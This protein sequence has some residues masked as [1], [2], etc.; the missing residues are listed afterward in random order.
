MS[1]ER[2]TKPIEYYKDANG[3]HPLFDLEV[4]G[5]SSFAKTLLDDTS[6]SEIRETISAQQTLPI[7]T[8]LMYDG[9]GIADVSTRTEDIGDREGDTISLPGWKVCNGNGGT[10]NLLNKFI[11]SEA[12]SGNTGGSDDA[13]VVSHSHS[14]SIGGSGTLYTNYT[15]PNLNHRHY[16]GERVQTNDSLGKYWT[17]YGQTSSGSGYNYT[18]GK[19]SSKHNSYQGYTSYHDH[20]MSHRHSI[21]SHGHSL[22][23]NTTGV[24]GTGKNMPAYYSLIFIKKVS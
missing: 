22:T 6:A 7:G 13:V 4:Y 16:N 20:S 8:I 17:V 12:S 1:L 15:D 18:A 24:D 3:T 11:R 10:P 9:T 14:G 5:V 19:S 21:N 23:I 2:G